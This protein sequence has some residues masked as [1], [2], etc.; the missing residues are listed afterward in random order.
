MD[1][2][3]EVNNVDDDAAIAVDE[4]EE[5]EARNGHVKQSR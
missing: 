2:D 4:T 1:F 5:E 3:D